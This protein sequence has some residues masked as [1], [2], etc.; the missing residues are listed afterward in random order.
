MVGGHGCESSRLTEPEPD[1]LVRAVDGHSAL[2]LSPLSH[3]SDIR[4]YDT[5]TPV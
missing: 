2:S 4:L 5:G 3:L 1:D